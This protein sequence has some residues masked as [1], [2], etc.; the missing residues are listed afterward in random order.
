VKEVKIGSV[1]AGETG[2]LH[3]RLTFQKLP[4][5]NGKGKAYLDYLSLDLHGRGKEKLAY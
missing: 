5:L 3:L 1:N 2:D 4:S